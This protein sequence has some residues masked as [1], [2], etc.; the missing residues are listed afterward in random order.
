MRARLL[1]VPRVDR[2]QRSTCRDIVPLPKRQ[3]RSC[4][5]PVRTESVTEMALFRHG[6][7]GADRETRFDV[8]LDRECRT[9]RCAVVVEVNPRRRAA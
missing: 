3:C 2:G 1:D 8:C 6:G 7:Y 5:G 9:V 4:G